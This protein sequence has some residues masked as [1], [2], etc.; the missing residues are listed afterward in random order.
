MS[1]KATS[2]FAAFQPTTVNDIIHLLCGISTNKA[3]GIDKISCKIIKIAAPA[4]SD[5]LTLIFN[6][7]IT[8]SSFPDEWKMTRVTPLYK[9]GQQNIPGNYRPIS[10]L[11]AIS[12][13]MEKIL[14]NQLYNYLTK[15]GLLSNSQFGFRKSHSTATPLLL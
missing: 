13:M 6:Q 7:A 4:I 11:P 1:K 14:Y 10:V 8:L 9:N 3:T 12:K 5:S 15:F 2:E